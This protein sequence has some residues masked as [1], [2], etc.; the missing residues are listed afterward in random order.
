MSDTKQLI[1]SL[2]EKVGQLVS[3][4]NQEK[5]ALKSKQEQIS[6]L[7]QQ[8]TAHQAEVSCI[9]RTQLILCPPQ[10]YPIPGNHV[11]KQDLYISPASKCYSS[12]F[13]P[14]HRDTFVS[15]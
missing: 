12:F 2:D 7:N 6:E 4:L 11:F 13:L 10:S 8:I 14:V 9:P 1:A 5:S 15:F 3:K